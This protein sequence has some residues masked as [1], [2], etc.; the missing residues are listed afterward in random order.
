MYALLLPS[1]QSFISAVEAKVNVDVRL[2]GVPTG[3]A[4][5]WRGGSPPW[6]AIVCGP[7]IRVLFLGA[8]WFF[9]RAPFWRYR[10]HQQAPIWRRP[11]IQHKSVASRC[12]EITL[13][14][15]WFRREPVCARRLPF[16]PA[17][18]ARNHSGKT[19]WNRRR[20]LA[21]WK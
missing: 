18:S 20:V 12:R 2:M 6:I 5:P 8:D 21:F 14:L 3:A 11:Q 16:G 1:A 7:S 4:T 10:S 19:P 17:H 13:L 15:R 9:I